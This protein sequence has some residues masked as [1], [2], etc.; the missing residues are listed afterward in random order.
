MGKEYLK[1]KRY[2]HFDKR[3]SVKEAK[4]LLCNENIIKNHGFFPFVHYTIKSKKIENVNDKVY[5]KKEPKKREIYYCAHFDR[6]IY[7]H[8]AHQLGTV[9]NDYVTKNG[10]DDCVG[11]YRINKGKCNIDI[12]YEMF[13]FIKKTENAIIIVGDFTGFFDNLNHQNLKR[14]LEVILNSKIDNNLY[15]AFKSLTRFKYIDIRD[16]YDYYTYRNKKRSEK[17]YMRKLEQL[18]T[19][20]E[21]RIFIKSRNT[22]TGEKYLKENKDDFGIVQG[23]PM[24][25]LLAN[26][27]MIDFDKEMHEFAIKNNG[28]YLRYSDDF[29]LVIKHTENINLFEVYDTIQKLVSSA[30]KIELEKRKTNIYKYN[31]E[32][33]YCIND[34]IFNTNNTT[35]VVN[36]LGFSFDGKSASIRDKTIS[37]YFY[38]LNRKIKQFLRGKKNI[39]VKN[40]YDKFSFQGENKKNS[41]GNKGN[42]ITYV[43]RSEQ[44]F[45]GEFRI[46][47]VRKNS[48]K[49]IT[50]KLGTMKL[51]YKD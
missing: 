22:V 30:G 11:A 42:F 51:K 16:L 13:K 12:S 36:F 24:S 27:Y 1:Y 9:Y 49:K 5:A 28:K 39:K 14:R 40:I 44:V 17:Y 15:K 46:S 37:K 23:S 47:D 50:E 31:N 2:A 20:E 48:K 4:K 41:K 6:Y 25:G 29:M 19:V 32:K 35:D 3:M 7:Q 34:M 26:I 10:I 33:I 38:K 45:K 21:F 8:Y 43:K 18:M